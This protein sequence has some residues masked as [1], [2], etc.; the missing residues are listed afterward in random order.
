[1]FDCSQ[2]LPYGKQKGKLF[3][4]EKEIK[5]AFVNNNNKKKNNNVY[6]LSCRVSNYMNGFRIS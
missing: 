6:G 2:S 3:I 5:Q 1:M 4:T